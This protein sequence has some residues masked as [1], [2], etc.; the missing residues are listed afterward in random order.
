MRRTYK[1]NPVFICYLFFKYVFFKGHPLNKARRR[2]NTI[3]F[4]LVFLSNDKKG[5]RKNA[6]T[7]VYIYI[8]I[9]A[10]MVLHI[11]IYVYAYMVLHIY[12]YVYIYVCMYVYI[13]DCIPCTNPNKFSIKPIRQAI[14]HYFRRLKQW[15]VFFSMKDSAKTIYP[16]IQHD[17]N[18]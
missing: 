8:Y 1:H 4:L 6:H 18:V 5:F 7:C 11:Y 17:V 3:G 16:F 14:A 2:T 13:L 9:Y 10:Y 12:I 15:S